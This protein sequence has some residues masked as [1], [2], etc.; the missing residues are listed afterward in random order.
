MRE[1][2]KMGEQTKRATGIALAMRSGV[3]KDLH[4]LLAS[5]SRDII[6]AL[7]LLYLFAR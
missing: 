5:G 4:T 1:R 2:V 6:Y 7:A 3:C